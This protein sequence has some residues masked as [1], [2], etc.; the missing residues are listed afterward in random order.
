MGYRVWG[1]RGV[2]CPPRPPP[3]AAAS[4]FLPV[5]AELLEQTIAA[6]FAT[7]EP[8]LNIEAFRLGRQT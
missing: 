2:V 8:E 5:K 4:P 3:P 7:R 1:E 6:L